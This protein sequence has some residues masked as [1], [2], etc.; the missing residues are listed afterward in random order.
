MCLLPE[1]AKMARLRMTPFGN[2]RCRETACTRITAAELYKYRSHVGASVTPRACLS[3]LRCLEKVDG[4]V[5][6]TFFTHAA[7]GRAQVN[8]VRL[9][10]CRRPALRCSAGFP[11]SVLLLWLLRSPAFQSQ[12]GCSLLTLVSAGFR[13]LP[14]ALI[15]PFWEYC[16]RVPGESSA[17]RKQP[18]N[19]RN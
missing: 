14:V 18:A 1:R 9:I 7:S 6:C 2:G 15:E 17:N 5:A 10:S 4:F 16:V 12:R 19:C 8:P 3:Q 11:R 13:V